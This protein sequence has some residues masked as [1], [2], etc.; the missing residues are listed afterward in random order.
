M[1]FDLEN[2]GALAKITDAGATVPPVSLINPQL[3]GTNFRFS[4]PSTSGHT[5][6]VQYST[7]LSSH[8]WLAYT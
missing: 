4:F 1:R 7:D 6:T 3:L 8:S 5:N 2:S